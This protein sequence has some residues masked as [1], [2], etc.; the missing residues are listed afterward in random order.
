MVDGDV[1]CSPGKRVERRRVTKTAD[2]SL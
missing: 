2:P 1:Q